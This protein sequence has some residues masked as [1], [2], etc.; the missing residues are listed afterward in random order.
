MAG[1]RWLFWACSLVTLLALILF[2]RTSP[3]AGLVLGTWLPLPILLVGWRQ[4]ARSAA[5]LA[6][7]GALFVLAL[8]PEAAAFQDN[9]GLW[10]ILLMGLLLVVWRQ[11]GWPE[12]SGIMVTVALVGILSLAF[13][14]G[15]AYFQGLS[16]MELWQARSRELGNALTGMLGEAGMSVSDLRVLGLP[17]GEVQNLLVQVLPALVL[18]NFA[19]IAWVNVLVGRGL[20]GAWG[21][22]DSG[23]ALSQWASPEWLVFFLVGAGFALLVPVAWVRQTGLN[24]VLVLGFVYFCQ[25]I[26]VIAALLQ[27]YQLPKVLRAVVYFLAF[28][29]PLMI[30]VTILGLTDLWLDF[31]TLQPPRET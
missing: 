23:E 13:F 21:W 28:M 19:L 5:P 1:S 18:L 15:Q 25:G 10:A 26:A 8:A 3:L 11:R 20:A 2:G 16:P 29:N 14:L 27:R 24:L 12:G 6:L 7:A 17:R 31:R 30:V 22:A 9:L 4:G